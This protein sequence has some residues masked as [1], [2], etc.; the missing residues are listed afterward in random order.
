MSAT[1]TTAIDRQLTTRTKR[2]EQGQLLCRRCNE[3]VPPDYSIVFWDPSDE[4]KVWG[5]CCSDECI[6]HLKIC[7]E[8]NQDFIIDKAGEITHVGDGVWLCKDCMTKVEICPHCN[9]KGSL[10][11]SPSGKMCKKCFDKMY[12]ICKDCNTLHVKL[13]SAANRLTNTEL[14]QWSHVLRGEEGLICGRCFKQRAKGKEPLPVGRCHCCQDVFNIHSR[15]DLF[16]ERC[17]DRGD[18]RLCEHCGIYS[19]RWD[20]ISGKTYCRTCSSKIIICECCKDNSFFN[21]EGVK[22]KG[23]SRTYLICKECENIS[24]ALE[25]CPSCLSLTNNPLRKV[26]GKKEVCVHCRSHYNWCSECKEFHFMERRCRK[27]GVAVCDYSYKP[28]PYFNGS[29]NDRV[30]FGFENEINYIEDNYEMARDTILKSYPSNILYA[31][32]DSSIA[33]SGFEVVSHPMSI[34]FFNALDLEPM[35]RV[36]P[37]ERDT[38]CGLHVHISRTSFDG[39]AHLFKLTEFINNNRSFTKKVAGRDFNSYAREYQDKISKAVKGTGYRERYHAVNLTNKKTVEI[40][41]FKSARNEFQL[42]YRIEFVSAVIEYTRSASI[43]TLSDSNFKVWLKMQPGY[44]E[45]K[46]FLKLTK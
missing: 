24:Y 19:T 21:G 31:K 1:L 45:L 43:Q 11:D 30:F 9:K 2:N 39:Q 3:V 4:T 25:E 38:S 35:F 37:R 42:R 16:C 40:R 13:D 5:P 32:R 10:V 27:D 17:I 29:L 6:C 28:Y 46:K 33:G 7:S 23:K 20:H 14:V 18:V 26:E 44:S 36:K 34:E 41:I 8:C 22:Y 15:S 12:F